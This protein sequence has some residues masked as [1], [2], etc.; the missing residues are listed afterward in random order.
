MPFGLM[1]SQA[2]FQRMIDRILLNVANVR[3]Y[4]NDVVIFSKTTEEHASHLENVFA[5]LKNNGLRLR[6]KKFSFMQPSVELLRHIVDENGV[7]VDEQKVEKVRD[8]IPATI[9]K[10]LRS[11]LGL[12]L[13]YSRFISGFSRITRPLNEKTSDNV[14][15]V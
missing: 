15:F 4:V 8:A 14:E 3:C 1:N 7:H 11:F 6:I 2:T 5:V 10:E 12:A 9:R 13:Y